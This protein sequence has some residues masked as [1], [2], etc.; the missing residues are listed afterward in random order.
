MSSK[1]R[2]T[3]PLSALIISTL[4]WAFMQMAQAQPIPG[5]DPA[6]PRKAMGEA[7]YQALLSYLK[8]EAPV[9]RDQFGQAAKPEGLSLTEVY[10]GKAPSGAPAIPVV[11]W[12]GATAQI[13]ILAGYGFFAVIQHYP[14]ESKSILLSHFK[15]AG[16]DMKQKT[17]ADLK[18]Y[19]TMRFPEE[20]KSVAV[21]EG[22]SKDNDLPRTLMLI[23]ASSNT[24]MEEQGTFPY[25]RNGVTVTCNYSNPRK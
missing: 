8:F 4:V 6:F 19:T 14:A 11:V 22:S 24:S 16:W 7:R 21:Y 13:E 3:R 18:N 10:S 17:L 20:A 5:A 2:N 9:Q 23:E 12:E 25:Y 15:K 1:L